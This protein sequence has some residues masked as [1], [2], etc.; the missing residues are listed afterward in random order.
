MTPGIAKPASLQADLSKS[1]G[2]RNGIYSPSPVAVG[3]NSRPR[4]VV[5]VFGGRG[6]KY[7]VHPEL[8]PQ[9]VPGAFPGDPPAEVA[10]KVGVKLSVGQNLVGALGRPLLF[11]QDP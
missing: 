6:V 4:G 7:I 1:D 11:G 3:L 5:R 8:P 2:H 10:L 9:A